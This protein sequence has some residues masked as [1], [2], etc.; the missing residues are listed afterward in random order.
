MKNQ[1]RSGFVDSRASNASAA[2]WTTLLIRASGTNQRK[3]MG[4]HSHLT[5]S[6]ASGDT[7]AEPFAKD[8]RPEICILPKLGAEDAS[9][10]LF[11]MVVKVGRADVIAEASM[12]ALQLVRPRDGNPQ[13]TCHVFACLDDK[14]SLAR[15][16]TQRAGRLRQARSRS[17]TGQSSVAA[18]NVSKPV[19]PSAPEP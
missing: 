8:H 15:S 3:D 9:F 1:L 4:D 10:C 12:M 5:Q 16:L 19:P 6:S 14:R 13:A 11:W 7:M 18:S 2:A 17:V